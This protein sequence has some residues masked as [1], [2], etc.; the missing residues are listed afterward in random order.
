MY[1]VFQYENDKWKWCSI[2]IDIPTADEQA[3]YL[4]GFNLGFDVSRRKR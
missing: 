4:L 3:A 2:T 1:C